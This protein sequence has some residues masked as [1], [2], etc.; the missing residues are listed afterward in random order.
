MH[1]NKDLTSN[2]E[3]VSKIS[4][5]I[6]LN[7]DEFCEAMGQVPNAFPWIYG[8]LEAKSVQ[9][10]CSRENENN[11]FFVVRTWLRI[12]LSSK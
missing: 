1:I 4:V 5:L 11:I 6:E 3:V 9:E 8:R 10:K 2:H 7:V 12:D